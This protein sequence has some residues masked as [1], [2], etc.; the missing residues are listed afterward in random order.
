MYQAFQ[1][2]RMILEL[3][4]K[5][6][7]KANIK[8][9]QKFKDSTITE[10]FESFRVISFLTLK[11]WVSNACPAFKRYVYL[12]N[13]F[14]NAILGNSSVL[15]LFLKKDNHMVIF[16]LKKQTIQFSFSYSFYCQQKRASKVSIF[17]WLMKGLVW[18]YDV[19]NRL[20]DF[21]QR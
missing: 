16:L 17:H 2:R 5:I 3:Y 21:F 9:A 10:W 1:K 4:S 20:K 7:S 14:C 12:Y 13:C 8:S 11:H 19:T 6:N 15:L 18:I